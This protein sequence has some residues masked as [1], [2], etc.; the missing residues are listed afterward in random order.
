MLP[1]VWRAA[2]GSLLLPCCLQVHVRSSISVPGTR[3]M[4]ASG[5]AGEGVADVAG[6]SLW[7]QVCCY[8]GFASSVLQR[9][10]AV[11]TCRSLPCR[12]YNLPPMCCMPPGIDDCLVS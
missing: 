5:C 11:N 2:A 8:L 1:A 6:C 3:A 10:A 4:R 9:L 7:L 12:R